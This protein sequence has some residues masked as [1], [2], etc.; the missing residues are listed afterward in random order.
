LLNL[1]I[2]T[3]PPIMD[4]NPNSENEAANPNFIFL[5]RSSL[6]QEK[7]QLIKVIT[8]KITASATTKNNPFEI[9]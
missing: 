2:K 9:S 7:Q 1:E 8:I 4:I 5:Q 3:K 6:T